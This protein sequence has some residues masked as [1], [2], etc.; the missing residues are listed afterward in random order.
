MFKRNLGIIGV[1]LVFFVVIAGILWWFYQQQNISEGN[2]IDAVPLNASFVLKINDAPDLSS[3]LR[4]KV[5]YREEL[6]EFQVFSKVYDIFQYVDTSAFFNDGPGNSLL[7]S[8]VYFSFSKE[9]KKSVEWSAHFSVSNTGVG[10]DL[11]N[12]MA[13]K[14]R[15]DREYTGF[16]IYNLQGLDVFKSPVYA[17]FQKGIFSISGSSLLIETSIRQQQSEHSLANDEGFSEMEKTTTRRADGALFIQFP[18]LDDFSS[19]FLSAGTE[20]ISFFLGNFAQWGGV[21][22]NVKDDAVMLNGFFQSH[23]KSF[24]LSVFNDVEPR[25]TSLGSVLPSDTRLFVGYNFTDGLKLLSNLKSYLQHSEDASSLNTLNTRFENEVGSSY[26]EFFFE[27]IEGEFAYGRSDFNASEPL[28]GRFAVFRTKGKMNSLPVMQK[29]QDYFGTT[30]EPIDHFR[31]DE[32]TSFPIFRGFKN[33]LNN[34]LWDKFF[35]E[36][37]MQY[38][39]FF[40]NYLVFADNTKTL[41][42]FLYDNIL[43]KTLENQSYYSSFRENFAYEENMFVF[44]E[45]PHLYSFVQDQLS[46]DFFHPTE[47]QIKVLYNF[48]GAGLQISDESDLSY[49]T[50][51]ASHAPHR[52]KDP[53][54]IWQSRIDS[55][56]SMKPALV[57]NHYSGEKEILVQDEGHNLYLINNRGRIL[58]KRALDGPVM[59]EIHQIDY[60]RNNKLQYL[61]NTP[62]KLY[63]LDRNGNHVARYPFNLPS[64]ATNGV[65]VFDYNENRNYRVFIALDDHKVYLF[66]KTGSRIAGWNIPTTE[67]IVN[68]P[69]QFFRT[70]G[71]DYIVFS[72]RYRNY[73]MDRRGNQRVKLTKSFR[74]NK[75]SAFFLEYPDSE[76]AALVTTTE[77]GALARVKLPSGRTS[78]HS[79]T[80]LSP[81]KAHT[82]LLLYK[83]EPKY[84]WITKGKMKIYG[85]ELSVIEEIQ[86]EDPM[87]VNGDVYRFSSHDHKIG[88]V[89]SI[90]N[91]IYLYNHDGSLYKGFP[92]TGTSRFS[93]GFLKTSAYRFNL[94]TGGENNYIYNY[95][96]E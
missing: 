16:S 56:V 70:S 8:P 15:L 76:K 77:D 13:D 87:N 54:T 31:V 63:L 59:S 61:F 38:F 47:K 6:A 25:R 46:A 78:I 45:I 86:F 36:V 18:E 74:R 65:A 62:D 12:W 92:L 68:Q 52:D 33:D 71:K 21:D 73:I 58:W 88:V 11:K 35:P 55:M 75:N 50:I 48:Y 81:E 30:Q 43:K 67:G 95:R 37:P 3:K 34:A 41:E 20:H 79:D 27:L 1:V 28:D 2:T 17:T 53:R 14:V 23:Q 72:D 10:R 4:N 26:P 96:V 24:F 32:S 42:S 49:T 29:L 83:N 19:P 89:D 85:T 64:R 57:D 82:F 91:Q 84:F 93:I 39:S 60:Y 94:I 7:D 90:Q 66:D 22:F 5:D 9:G 40:R 69:V 44:A 80:S 51:Y